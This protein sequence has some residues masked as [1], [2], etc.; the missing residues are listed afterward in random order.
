MRKLILGMLLSATPNEDQTEKNG[1]AISISAAKAKIVSSAGE[2]AVAFGVIY[3]GATTDGQS[4]IAPFGSGQI[5]PVKLAS[6]SADVA[7]GDYGTLGTDGTFT[8][9]AGTGS[10]VRCVRFTESGSA[11]ETVGALLLDLQALS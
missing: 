2:Q 9:D 3:D 7:A 11:G 1:Y 10:R 8:K 4:S 5:V 6:G